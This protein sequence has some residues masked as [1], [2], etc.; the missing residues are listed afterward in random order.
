MT[1][2]CTVVSTRVFLLCMHI[3]VMS[4]PVILR[5]KF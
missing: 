2:T 1:Y 5:L 3:L 4:F